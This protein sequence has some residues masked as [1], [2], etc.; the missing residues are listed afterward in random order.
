MTGN[1]DPGTRSTGVSG[2]VDGTATKRT[3]CETEPLLAH[4]SPNSQQQRQRQRLER[5]AEKIERSDQVIAA[6]ARL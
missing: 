6:L 4:P 1:E 2:R 5:N 3:V